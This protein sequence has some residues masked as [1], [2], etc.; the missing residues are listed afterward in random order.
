MTPKNC[1][2]EPESLTEGGSVKSS[3]RDSPDGFDHEAENTLLTFTLA[4]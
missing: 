4:V 3:S 1:L 2:A